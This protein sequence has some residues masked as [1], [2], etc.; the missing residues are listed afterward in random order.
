MYYA[1]FYYF[2]CFEVCYLFLF[3]WIVF[4]WS[5]SIVVCISILTK[6]TKSLQF[7]TYNFFSKEYIDKFLSLIKLAIIIIMCYS[8]LGMKE[9]QQRGVDMGDC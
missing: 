6:C 8:I 5:S 4:S 1:V 9:L 2:L 7:S 3:F